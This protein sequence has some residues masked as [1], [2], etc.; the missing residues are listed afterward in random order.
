MPCPAPA[1]LPGKSPRASR[2][3]ARKTRHRHAPGTPRRGEELRRSRRP[4]VP[5]TDPKTG[6]VRNG[7]VFVAVLSASRYAYA[8]ATWTRDLWDWIGS[9]TR[10]FEYFGGTSALVV[11][12]THGS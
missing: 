3:W 1:V 8:E 5:V 4:T 12:D 11:P 6:E 10:A 2:E 9:H 7:Y